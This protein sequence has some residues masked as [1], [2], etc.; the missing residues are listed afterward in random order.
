GRT[1]ARRTYSGLVNRFLLTLAIAG[2][3]GWILAPQLT[4]LRV[5][6]FGPADIALA[7]EMFRWIIPLILLQVAAELL[8]TLANAERMY[9]TPEVVS[10]AA[11]MLSLGALVML[12]GS[13][14]AWA[15]VVGLWCASIVEVAAI[16]WLLWRRGYRHQLSLSLPESAGTVG[17]FGKLGATLPYVG[18]TQV[19]AFVF[20]AALSN[21]PQ[22]SF[23]VFRYATMIWTRTQGVFLRPL[24]VPF[25]TEFSDSAARGLA[26]TAQITEVALARV[27]AVTAIV[28]TAVLAGAERVLIGLW[29]GEQFPPA[30]ISTLVWLL[31]GLYL[32]LPLT[33]TAMVLRKVTVS[34][35]RVRETYGAMALVQLISAVLAWLLVSRFGLPG[36][37]GVMALNL[38]GFCAAPVVVLRATGDAFRFKYPLGRVWRWSLAATLGILA[39][40]LVDRWII[41]FA[42]TASVSRASSVVVGCLLASVGVAVAYGVSLLLRVPESRQLVDRVIRVLSPR[43]DAEA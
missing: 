19:F 31:A 4:R 21:L 9:G 18:L 25:F 7:T 10:L 15:M 26:T 3:A 36:A 40:V 16:L 23:A 20:D 41:A 22:G 35:H 34:L 29:Q 32:L 33:G 30:K 42:G 1:V 13:V 2:L 24:S 17:L 14:G 5:P 39:G 28:T 38:V 12:A 43:D 6:G 8:K 11:R 37:L 27:L